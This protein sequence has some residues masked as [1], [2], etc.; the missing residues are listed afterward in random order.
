M[1]KRLFL[2]TIFNKLLKD[3]PNEMDFNI[4]V[5]NRID[6]VC[7]LSLIFE[8][9]LSWKLQVNCVNDKIARV[10]SLLKELY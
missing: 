7:Y 4:H 3:C 8:C 10:V 6:Y 1:L 5:V 9:N 2:F